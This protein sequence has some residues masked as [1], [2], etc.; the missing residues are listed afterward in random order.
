[1]NFTREYK[2]STIISKPLEKLR[3]SRRV[4]NNSIATNYFECEEINS[5]KNVVLEDNSFSYS[6]NDRRNFDQQKYKETANLKYSS[7]YKDVLFTIYTGRNINNESI[8]LFFKQKV[9]EGKKIARVQIQKLTNSPT[10]NEINYGYAIVDGELFYNYENKYNSITKEY[11]LYYLTISYTDGKSENTIINPIPA[12]EK[13][14]AHNSDQITYSKY[15]ISRG[16]EYNILTP[17][18]KT[19]AQLLCQL[20]VDLKLYIKELETNSIYLK[21]PENQNVENEWIPEIVAGEVYKIT[22]TEVLRYH[23]PEYRNQNFSIEAPNLQVFD[24]DCHVVTE[25]IIKLPLSKITYDGDKFSLTIKKYDLNNE[26][27]E[28]ELAI[29]K[30]DEKN[31]F[32]ELTNALEF[33]SGEDY[34]IRADFFY[35]TDTY[36]YSRL[37]LNPFFNKK[38]LKEKYHFFVK[39]NEDV[40]SIVV[41]NTRDDAEANW[42]Y[43]GAIFYEEDY[44]KEK[45]FSFYLEKRAR[46]FSLDEAISK[47]PYILQSYLGYG[48]QGQAIQKNNVVVIDLPAEYADQE[49]YTEEELINLFK[50]KLRPG[51]NIILNY[52]EDEPILKFESFKAPEITMTLS[53]EGPGNYQV[54]RSSDE[55]FGGAIEVYNKDENNES[56]PYSLTIPDNNLDVG[57]VYYYKVV[58]NGKPTKRKYSLKVGGS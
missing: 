25:K 12:I 35:K 30:V 22:D 56:Y 53:W 2:V 29:H 58:F 9:T 18:G 6:F 7:L 48:S 41:Q 44:N 42:L 27:V 13:R 17:K 45:S 10:G 57:K 4:D 38:N 24:K 16:Y 15:K 20:D 3:Y 40:N 52:V 50:R 32:V 23:I 31:G 14:T 34:Y 51:V 55:N 21:K 39:P 26:Q 8:P 43:L 54:L 33:Q 1:M 11:E 36:Y 37:D 19:V 49:F 28:D 46:I 5:S 47:N